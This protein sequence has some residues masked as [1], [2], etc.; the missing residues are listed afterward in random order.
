MPSRGVWNRRLH[1]IS[2]RLL[3]IS[4]GVG[5]VYKVLACVYLGNS[6]EYCPSEEITLSIAAPLLSSTNIKSD[7]SIPSLLSCVVV[8]VYVLRRVVIEE[9]RSRPVTFE[10]YTD[11]LLILSISSDDF[12]RAASSLTIDSI[13]SLLSSVCRESSLIVSHTFSYASP[14]PSAISSCLYLRLAWIWACTYG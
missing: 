4:P 1:Q 3:D 8:P 13:E 10:R 7:T 6:S 9:F 11:A 14:L 12:P 2:H 5:D